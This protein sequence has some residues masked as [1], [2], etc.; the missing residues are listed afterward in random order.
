MRIQIKGAT[1]LLS[2]GDGFSLKEADLFTDGSVI[3]AIG[4]AP[5]G[6]VPDRIL[7]GGDRLVIPGLINSHTHNYMSIF[8]NLADDVPFAQWLFEEVEPRENRMTPEDAY[9][10]A[11]LGIMEMLRTGTTCF[12]DMQMHIHQTPR[13]V[14]DTGIRGVIGRGLSGNEKDEGGKR[15]LREAREE[16]SRWQGEERISFTIAPHAPYSCS[17]GYLRQA[18]EMAAE[19]NLPLH[20]HLSESD[21]EVKTMMEERKI[22]PIAYASSLGLL[23]QPIIVAHC[24]KINEEDIRLL[25][26]PLVSVVTNPASNM[27]LGNGF[28]PVVPMLKAG[29]NLC[30]GTDGAASNNALNLFREMGF[31]ALIHKGTTLDAEAVSATQVLKMATENGARALG[32]GDKIGKIQVGYQADLA[33]LN[34]NVPQLRP[35]N[36]LISSLTY[37]ANGSEVETVLVAG[38]ICMENREFTHIDEERVYAEVEKRMK[39]MS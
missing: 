8:R 23:D 29:V 19:M 2:E 24:V 12:N 28:A 9:W 16:I 4:E 31:L 20:I 33:I 30:V 13:A 10:G 32:M 5:R 11:T 38:E 6:Y 1:L 3:A 18:A 17:E 37:S 7:E 39:R 35:C 27:K 22:T 34:L 36:N 26:K 15:R 21:F 14:V 25:A